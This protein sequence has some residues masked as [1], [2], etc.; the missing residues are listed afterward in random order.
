MFLL[1]AQEVTKIAAGDWLPYATGI[2][3]IGFSI[4]VAWYLLSKAIPNMQD[5]FSETLKEQR[6]DHISA[7]ERERESTK[8]IFEMMSSN[9]VNEI[10]EINDLV[11]ENSVTLKLIADRIK[12]S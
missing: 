1:F 12:V 4:L 11:R 6:A 10:R 5:K 9:G 2:A 7:M 8:K 3:N